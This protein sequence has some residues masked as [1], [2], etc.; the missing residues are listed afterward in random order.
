M[1]DLTIRE[2]GEAM[3]GS[4]WQSEMARELGKAVNTVQRWE[5]GSRS[6]GPDSRARLL[7]LM[8][9]RRDRLDQVIAAAEAAVQASGKVF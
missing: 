4:R 9:D 8:R 6:P 3:Y 2:I 5:D 7:G 1:P